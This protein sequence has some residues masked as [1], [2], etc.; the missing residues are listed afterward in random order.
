MRFYNKPHRYYCGIDLHTKTMYVC[1]LKTE[2][3]AKTR[4]PNDTHDVTVFSKRSTP[5]LDAMAMVAKDW[6]A[7]QRN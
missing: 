2:G 3:E 5:D 7:K 6:S 1:I 4:H